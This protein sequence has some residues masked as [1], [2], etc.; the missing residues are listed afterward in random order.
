M[1][2][3]P[4]ITSGVQE[5]PASVQAEMT[6]LGAMLLEPEQVFTA[7]E[8]LT[9]ND[10]SLSSHREIFSAMLALIEDGEPIDFTTLGNALKDRSRLE[11]VGGM[12]YLFSITEGLPR[13]LSITS[14]VKIVRD[15]AIG[16]EAMNI[17][18]RYSA[19]LALQADPPLSVIAQMELELL[20]LSS[21][22]TNKQ[23]A[24][25]LADVVPRVIAKIEEQRNDPSRE[26][27]LGYTYGI[28]EM[29]RFTKGAFPNEYTIIL[30]ETGGMKTAWL[31][32]ILLANAIKGVGSLLFSM[33]MTVDQMVR[34]MLSSI[35]YL[36]KAK[37]IRDPRFMGLAEFE[38]LKKTGERLARLGI[39]ID[40]SRQLPLDQMLA[41]SRVAIQRDESKLIAVD[42]LQ[43]MRAPTKYANLND[44]QRIEMVTLA[45]RDL[46]A[47]SKDYGAHVIAL[48][49]Y[50]RPMDGSKPRPTN[51]RAKGSSSLEQSAHNMF[52]IVREVLEDGSLSADAEIRIGKQREG[53]FGSIQCTVDEDHLRLKERAA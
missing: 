47:D 36:V 52:H 20:D 4:Q 25:M 8:V 11:A 19:Q 48:S 37:D 28:P 10:F 50:S 14:Y 2:S 41:R 12:P 30:A 46:A 26:D 27:A 43:L 5:R 34:R 42:Y 33:E 21:A 39:K 35:S 1:A 6:I 51:S 31:A 24:E 45:L 18:D 53:K 13:R 23:N 32:Q 40:D 29:D 38:D 44:T 16:R 3:F 9:T 15:K 22:A 49:Q 7:T 17:C